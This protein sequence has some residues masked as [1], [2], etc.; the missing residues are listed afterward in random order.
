MRGREVGSGFCL[1]AGSFGTSLGAMLAAEI[2]RGG[3]GGA[4]SSGAGGGAVQPEGGGPMLG[5]GGRSEGFGPPGPDWVARRGNSLAR[6]GPAGVSW[7]EPGSRGDVR[8]ACRLDSSS[9]LSSSSARGGRKLGRRL[10]VRGGGG[11][12]LA[13]RNIPR[14]AR[15]IE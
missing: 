9:P 11:V 1:S 10:L 3:P 12:V 7:A 6:S 2:A 14:R 13:V 8:R 15:N 4:V 5:G